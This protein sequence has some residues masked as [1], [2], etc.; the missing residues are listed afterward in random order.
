VDLGALVHRAKAL[1]LLEEGGGHPLAA[2]FSILRPHL[3]DFETFLIKETQGIAYDP[4]PIVIESTLSLSGAT[5]EL[6]AQVSRL[7]PFGTGNLPPRFL[8]SNV[9]VEHTRVVGKNHVSCTLSQN[10]GMRVPGIAFRSMGTPR[11]DILLAHSGLYDIVGTIEINTWGRR[12]AVQV[13]IE[14]VSRG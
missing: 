8:F 4:P 7:G 3:A 2:G 10:N 11:G 12:T 5:S 1:G 13:H 9:Y 6:A 14:D